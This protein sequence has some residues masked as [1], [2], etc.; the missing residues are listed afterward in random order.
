MAMV[1]SQE[2]SLNTGMLD[3]EEVQ[4]WDEEEEEERK[5]NCPH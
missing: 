1:D 5:R 2:V 3:R 4:E